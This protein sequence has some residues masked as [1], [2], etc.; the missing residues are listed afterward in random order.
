MIDPV[1]LL[2]D[3]GYRLSPVASD[4]RVFQADKG[5]VSF[6]VIDSVYEFDFLNEE[7]LVYLLASEKPVLVHVPLNA[8]YE[9]YLASFQSFAGFPVSFFIQGR[10]DEELLT[11]QSMMNRLQQMGM[12]K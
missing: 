10:D 11:R 4:L 3:I 8:P 12:E 2:E 9:E 6:Y 7:A 1:R 5:E